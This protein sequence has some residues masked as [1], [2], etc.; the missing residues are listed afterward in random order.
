MIKGP[1]LRLNGSW[2]RVTVKRL[3]ELTL[4]LDNIFWRWV[5]ELRNLFWNHSRGQTDLFYEGCATWTSEDDCLLT[6]PSNITRDFLI[7]G[8]GSGK[9][10]LIPNS[11]LLPSHHYCT[12]D[13]KFFIKLD[14]E[15]VEEIKKWKFIFYFIEDLL[16]LIQHKSKHPE[17]FFLISLLSIFFVDRDKNWNK[18]N[19]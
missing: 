16:F 6:D 5:Y 14:V 12:S 7:S 13:N 15:I 11:A 10:N 4:I 17:L 9:N 8:M 3:W 19:M 2:S 18:Y 1:K